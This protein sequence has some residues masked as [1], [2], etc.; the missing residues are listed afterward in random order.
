[1]SNPEKSI[2]FSHNDWRDEAACKG[3]S[4]AYFYDDKL[5]KMA[6]ELCRNECKVTEECREYAIETKQQYG[7]WGGVV[8][9]STKK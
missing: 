4:L 1:M 7:V 2:E 3:L 9:K 6:I 8:F 5:Q